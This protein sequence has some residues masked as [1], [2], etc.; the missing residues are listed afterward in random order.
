M[1]TRAHHRVQ[2]ATPDPPARPRNPDR[3]IG[4]TPA[5]RLAALLDQ[6]PAAAIGDIHLA[7]HAVR[8]LDDGTPLRIDDHGSLVSA[9][10][11]SLFE[12]VI[13]RLGP[14][15]TLIE[16]DIDIPAFDVL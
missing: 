10:V 5:E 4:E 9:E 16:W 7:G 13:G 12:A 3:R 15:P 2:A 8:L 14:R 1:V 11:W 6:V